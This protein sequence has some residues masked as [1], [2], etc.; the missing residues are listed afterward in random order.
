MHR[1]HGLPLARRTLAALA[2]AAAALPAAAA[3]P[4]SERAVLEALYNQTHGAGWA[5]S[6]HWMAATD[7]CDAAARWRGITCDA[8]GTHV[9]VI[10]LDGN[11]L[12]GTLPATLNQLTALVSFRA[13][14]NRLTGS[15]P[16]L[17][18]LTALRSFSVHNNQLTGSIPS[19]SG[20]TALERLYVHNNRLTGSIPKLGG[21]TALRSFLVQNNRLTGSIPNLRGLMALEYFY[22]ANNQ[23]TGTIPPSISGLTA[24]SIFEA[25]GNQLTGAPPAAPVHLSAGWSVLCSNGLVPSP[26]A[27]INAAWDAATGITPWSRDC[28]VPSA[29][30]P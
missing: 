11:K 8:D 25:N 15:I 23:L 2:L 6:Q 28:T 22:V 12:T 27:A 26:D 30:K 14:S 5:R 24:L 19:L 20:L 13:S 16:E 18:G 1:P 21:L 9:T 10:E 17:S 29:P 3:I 7:P 4:A